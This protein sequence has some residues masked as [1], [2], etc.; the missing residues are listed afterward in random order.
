MMYASPVFIL[1]LLVILFG[2]QPV[3]AQDSVQHFSA[4]I[5]HSAQ[6]VGHLIEGSAKLT[7]AVIAVPLG[8]SAQIGAVSGQMSE[9]MLDYA[10]T[11][12]GTPLPVSDEVFTVGP[13]PAE[14]ITINGGS[15]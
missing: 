12:I 13:S 11:P 4:G 5:D 6:S 9:A 3:L 14:A 8:L 7:S 2:S 10:N 1:T 15:E